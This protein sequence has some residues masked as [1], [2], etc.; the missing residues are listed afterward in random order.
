MVSISLVNLKMRITLINQ[1]FYPDVVSTAQHL[2]DLALWLTE[3]GHEVTVVAS[4][5]AYDDPKKLFPNE[6]TWRGITIA[7]VSNTGLGKQSKLT[8]IID[9][10]T[11]ILACCWR[12][13]W[14]PRQDLVVA[15]TS[16]PIISFI[17]ALFV[18]IRGGRFCYW[19][20]DLNPDEAVAAGWLNPNSLAAK[21]LE[22][23]SRFSL[24]SA[25]KIVV[26]DE[27]MREKLLNKG[28][29]GEKIEILPPWSHDSE[30]S[31]DAAGRERFR[32]A[33]GLQGKFVVMYSGNHSPCHPLDTIMAAAQKLADRPDI[34]F[35]FVGG[36]SEFKRVKVFAQTNGLS[37]VLCLPYQPIEQLAGSLSAADLHVVVM[38]NPFV[39]IVHP[40]KI[41]NIMLVGAPLLYVGPEPSHISAILNQVGPGVVWVAAGHGE[42][43]AVTKHILHVKEM[44][45]QP[46]RSGGDH[47]SEKYSSHA[48]VPRL[49]KIMEAAGLA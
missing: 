30:V 42:V 29:A 49:G 39:G 25:Q 13:L 18:R 10:G 8:R 46:S 23:C 43:D 35:C 47:V 48:L 44:K 7:R 12:L 32:Q 41:Y 9:F 20:M 3:A 17:G 5:R 14:L 11:F 38:G 36:G 37:N 1:T 34:A 15:L 19:V 31:F 4:R 33:H 21:W 40:C 6:E 28:I 16:P 26:L 2:K 22:G 45:T 24:R 27:F